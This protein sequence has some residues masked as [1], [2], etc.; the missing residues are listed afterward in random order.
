MSDE[1][2]VRWM[3]K[4]VSIRPGVRKGKNIWKVCYEEK[5]EIDSY[6]VFGQIFKDYSIRTIRFPPH[7]TKEGAWANARIEVDKKVIVMLEQ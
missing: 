5:K 1:M 7:E 4:R 2:Y 6:S 3:L